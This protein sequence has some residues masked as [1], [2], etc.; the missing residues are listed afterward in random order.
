[1]A[2]LAGACTHDE[3]A[4][5]GDCEDAAA[6]PF[7]LFFGADVDVAAHDVGECARARLEREAADGEV[8]EGGEDA[9]RCGALEA[10]VVV[11]AESFVEVDAFAF[12]GC[13]AVAPKGVVD[14]DEAFAYDGVFD[15]VERVELVDFLNRHFEVAHD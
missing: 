1:M 7:G 15:D 2:D 5:S 13:F 6:F 8:D 14:L 9:E 12:V 11:V 3:F 10:A 4:V